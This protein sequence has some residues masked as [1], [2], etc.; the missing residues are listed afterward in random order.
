MGGIR[1]KAMQLKN[2]S[3]MSVALAVFHRETSELKA[4]QP[5]NMP[6]KVMAFDTSQMETSEFKATQS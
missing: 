3:Y 6:H 5:R 4:A 2:I 1:Y